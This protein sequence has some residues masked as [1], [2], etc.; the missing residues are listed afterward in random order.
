MRKIYQLLFISILFPAISFAHGYW[1]ETVGTHKP[2]E[3]VTVKLFYG[4]YVE[5][6]R[7][8]GKFLDRMKEISIFVTS[9]DGKKQSIEMKQLAEYWEGTFTP[10]TNGSYSITGLNDTREVQDWTQHNLGIV[11]PVQYLQTIY[12]VGNTLTKQ[13]AASF[14]AIKVT[15]VAENKYEITVTKNDSAFKSLPLVIVHPG[16]WSKNVTTDKEGKASFTTVGPALYLID[17]EWIDKT[18][19]TFKDKKY[20]TVRH[21]FD[22]SFYQL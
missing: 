15:P 22:Y 11:R 19:G 8:S 4:E 20:E 9:P 1:I 12:Q 5:G 17:V 14:L 18:S 13:S 10:A 16:G 21:K 7:L 3:A 2:N 6:E